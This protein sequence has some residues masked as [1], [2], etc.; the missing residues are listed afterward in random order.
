MCTVSL[1]YHSRAKIFLQNHVCPWL[2]IPLSLNVYRRIIPC[3]SFYLAKKK[4]NTGDYIQHSALASL[5]FECEGWRVDMP[6]AGCHTATQC[7]PSEGWNWFWGYRNYC[8]KNNWYSEKVTHWVLAVHFIIV[9]Q[10][11]T[12]QIMSSIQNVLLKNAAY[13]TLLLFVMFL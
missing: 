3:C 13:I 11:H 1:Q 4:L 9:Q 5:R 8:T 12:F 6:T 10:L 2:R 7:M